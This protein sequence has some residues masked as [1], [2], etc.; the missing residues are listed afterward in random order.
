[1]LTESQL[2]GYESHCPGNVRELQNVIG[3][4]ILQSESEEN[5]KEIIRNTDKN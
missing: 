3:R 4:M 5:I 1:M 2:F